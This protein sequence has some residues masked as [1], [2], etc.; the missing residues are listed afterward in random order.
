MDS[1]IRALYVAHFED[2]LDEEIEPAKRSIVLTLLAKER[3]DQPQ[4]HVSGRDTET[5]RPRWTGL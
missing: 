3:A 4:R 2:L 1:F 5:T